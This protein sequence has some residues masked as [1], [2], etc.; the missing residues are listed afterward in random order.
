MGRGIGVLAAAILVFTV[1]SIVL[2]VFNEDLFDSANIVVNIIAGTVF[3]V[4]G[5]YGLGLLVFSHDPSKSARAAIAPPHQQQAD[6]QP[7]VLDEKPDHWWSDKGIWISWWL[8]LLLAFAIVL[9]VL[10]KMVLGL[11][12]LEIGNVKIFLRF[13]RSSVQSALNEKRS[14]DSDFALEYNILKV[15][16]WELLYAEK[17]QTLYEKKKFIITEVEEKKIDMIMGVKIRE[18]T[19]SREFLMKTVEPF[20]SCGSYAVN[21]GLHAK[22]VRRHSI[23]I[24]RYY[25][26][27]LTLD[28][29]NS[30]HDAKVKIGRAEKDL[31]IAINKSVREIRAIW[32]KT[33]KECASSSKA[34]GLD[35]LVSGKTEKNF[36]LKDVQANP[37]P[38]IRLASLFLFNGE[39]DTALRALQHRHAPKRKHFALEQYIAILNYF[40]EK[41]AKAVLSRQS[42]AIAEL[43]IIRRQF[44]WVKLRNEKKELE[45]LRKL[46]PRIE[47]GEILTKNIYAYVAAQSKIELELA[48]EY[49]SELEKAFQG[50]AKKPLRIFDA[51]NEK[52]YRAAI[53][54]TIAYVSIVR[55]AQDASAKKRPLKSKEIKKIEK[56]LSLL[57]QAKSLI[58]EQLE[59][60]PIKPSIESRKMNFN[61]KLIRQHQ[62]AAKFLLQR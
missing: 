7:A 58:E 37:Y 20:I 54:D 23:D 36:V 13:D 61:L 12:G 33:P 39:P 30:T 26:K 41:S 6:P 29:G 1:V 56:A 19:S 50:N 47:R 38:W 3:G 28:G 32:S 49:T 55:I 35:R 4:I 48:E 31:V 57:N 52:N 18:I 10:E 17:I 27:L 2:F 44:D 24:A 8:M 51:S 15:L 42:E 40:S 59:K 9:P 43:E 11:S 5:S 21:N 22:F 46:S 62:S 60:V 14:N 53:L 34:Y 25:F 16:E 45:V